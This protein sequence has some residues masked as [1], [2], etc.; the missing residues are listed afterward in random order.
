MQ[1][2]VNPAIQAV[3]LPQTQT[4]QKPQNTS[5]KPQQSQMAQD[6]AQNSGIKKGIMPT[7]KGAGAGLLVG[8]GLGIG[9][10]V[11]I[12]AVTHMG[13]GA[14]ALMLIPMVAA[15]AGAV[16]GGISANMTD[17]IGEGALWGAGSGAVVGGAMGLTTGN[18]GVAAMGAGIGAVAGAAT[19]SIGSWMAE[20]E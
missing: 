6:V 13:S 16:A 9:T 14:L 7:L 2:K 8:G 5:Q 18:W 4:S 17:S 1:V 19:G 11:A 3:G 12:D 10:A 20:R 15:P